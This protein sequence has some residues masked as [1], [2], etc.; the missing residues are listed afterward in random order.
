MQSEDITGISGKGCTFYYEDDPTPQ[1]GNF[2]PFDLESWWGKR[3]Y[4]F[5]TNSIDAQP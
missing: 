3:L 4:T 5:I 2:K 1:L